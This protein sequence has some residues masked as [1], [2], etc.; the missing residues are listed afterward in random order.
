MATL[1][2]I[3]IVFI[4]TLIRKESFDLLSETSLG[5]T[6]LP[7]E[8]DFN[9]HMNNGSYLKMMDLARSDHAFKIKNLARVSRKYGWKSVV[10]SVEINYLRSISL[11]Q[12]YDIYTQ[13]SHWDERWIYI[14][15]KFVRQEKIMAIALVKTVVIS[16]TQGRI[17]PQEVFRELG[18][19]IPSPPAMPLFSGDLK[20]LENL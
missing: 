15:Q 17:S 5:F 6:S 16:K 4:R 13:I 3:L 9:G 7:L 10:G 2:R 20:K 19:D 12:F 14:K 1:F 8:M 18:Y 11:F